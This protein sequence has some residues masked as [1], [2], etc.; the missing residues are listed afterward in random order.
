MKPFSKKK[1]ERGV[2]LALW[3]Y[4][5]GKQ[6]VDNQATTSEKGLELVAWSDNTKQYT[7]DD[8]MNIHMDHH[9]VL[10]L[11]FDYTWVCMD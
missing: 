6:N 8:Y 10:I 3:G 11:V 4:Y 2:F 1:N 7:F 5:L 9:S